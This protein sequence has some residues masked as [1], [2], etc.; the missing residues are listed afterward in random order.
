MAAGRK[1]STMYLLIWKTTKREATKIITQTTRL[2]KYN[3]WISAAVAQPIIPK[4]IVSFNMPEPQKTVDGINKMAMAT[5]KY[6][7]G[8][9][10]TKEEYIAHRP[11][12]DSEANI[13]A[14]PKYEPAVNI[15]NKPAKRTTMYEELSR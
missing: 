15:D 11:E 13:K 8:N 4:V 3:I 14:V 6:F 2:R 1:L 10:F 5:K 7:S 9:N 12:K